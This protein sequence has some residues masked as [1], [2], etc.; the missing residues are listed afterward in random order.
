MNLGIGE[1]LMGISE[2]LGAAAGARPPLD[3][4]LKPAAHEFEASLMKE[5]LAPLEHD[6]LC[7]NET[8]SESPD[9]SGNALMSYGTEA[10]AKA[11]S[12]RGGFGIADRILAHFAQREKPAAKAG[13]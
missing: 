10:L 8:D 1:N 11:I 9:G 5:L 13:P 7:N 12:D 6:P 2:K 4:R 3:P